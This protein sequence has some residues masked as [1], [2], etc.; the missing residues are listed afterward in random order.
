MA[1][2]GQQCPAKVNA[3]VEAPPLL[4]FEHVIIKSCAPPHSCWQHGMN[5]LLFVAQAGGVSGSRW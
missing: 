4:A 3:N 2:V 5:T 1:V